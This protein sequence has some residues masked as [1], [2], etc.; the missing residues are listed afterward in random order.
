[1]GGYHV[2]KP[3]MKTNERLVL[4]NQN[5]E[6]SAEALDRIARLAM[7]QEFVDE[8]FIEKLQEREN[9][10]PTGLPMPVPLAIPHTREGCRE[11]FMSVATLAEPIAFKSMDLSGDEI[12]AQIVFVFGILDANTQLDVL[13]KFAQVFANGDDVKRLLAAKSGSELLGELND[14]LD[15]LLK[16][17]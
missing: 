12:Q 6:N 8:S 10:Y 4:L 14:I 7:E 3:Q 16:I 13:S 11:S 17:T 5:F 15:G 2:K 1:M 9:E